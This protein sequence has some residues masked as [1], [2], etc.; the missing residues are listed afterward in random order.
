ME[1][2]V[3]PDQQLDVDDVTSVQEPQPAV[4]TAEVRQKYI[5]DQVQGEIINLSS[6]LQHSPDEFIGPRTFHDRHGLINKP[7][8][9]LQKR[10]NEIEVH[11]NIHQMPLLRIMYM[12]CANSIYAYWLSIFHLLTSQLYP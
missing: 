2:P 9:L 8:T 7:D 12:T 1:V 4:T 3:Q 6:S 10:L 11:S 5:D